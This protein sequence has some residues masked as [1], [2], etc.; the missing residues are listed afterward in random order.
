MITINLITGELSADPE[1]AGR[2]INPTAKQR[3]ARHLS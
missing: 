3:S 1:T 2:D